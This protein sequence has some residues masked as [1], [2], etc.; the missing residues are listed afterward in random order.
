MALTEITLNVNLASYS[1][2]L[3][4]PALHLLM[5]ELCEYCHGPGH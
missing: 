4:S 1:D 3:H 2:D 5:C